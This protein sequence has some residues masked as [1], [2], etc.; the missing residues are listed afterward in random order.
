MMLEE[1]KCTE[2]SGKMVPGQLIDQSYVTSGPQHWA[3][4]ATSIMGIGLGH[5]YPII[6]YRC[7]KC[8]Y[9]KNYA[10][11]EP[12]D[13]DIGEGVKEFEDKRESNPIMM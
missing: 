9:L 8:G 11:E 2:C 5:S 6:S 12:V 4:K 7:E 3:K 1:I 13:P 10:P